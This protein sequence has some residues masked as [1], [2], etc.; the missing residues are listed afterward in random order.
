MKKIYHFNYDY[1]VAEITIVVNTDILTEEPARAILDFYGWHYNKETD[2]IGEVIK[3]CAMDI[4]TAGVRYGN[5]LTAIKKHLKENN[6]LALLGDKSG[7][8]AIAFEPF[9]FDE[10]RLELEK[11]ET[12]EN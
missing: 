2:C 10:M 4:I 3:K 11:I 6:E 5:D 9:Q 7:I 8:T 1:G 12:M